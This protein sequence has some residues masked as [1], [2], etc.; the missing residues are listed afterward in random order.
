MP[1]TSTQPNSTCEPSPEALRSWAESRGL[2]WRPEDT[3]P[4]VTEHL[5]LGLG[6]GERRSGLQTVTDDGTVV[7]DRRAKRPERQTLGVVEGNLPGGLN[8][9]LGHH[10]FLTARSRPRAEGDVR[11]LAHAATALFAELPFGARPVFD[12]R[13]HHSP[14]ESPRDGVSVGPTQPNVDPLSTAVPA[15]ESSL[16]Y[17]DFTW[18]GFPAESDERIATIVAEA[19]TLTEGLPVERIEVEYECGRL[20]VWVIGRYLTAPS[21]LDQLSRFASAIASGMAAAVRA[22]PQFRLEETVGTLPGDQRARWIGAGTDLLEWDAPPVSIYAA[23]E[24]YKRDVKP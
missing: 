5:R 10:V 1:A 7:I 13:G 19:V 9:C 21:A 14:E 2:A 4:P 17:A 6:A 8:G 24:R 12:L 22:T 15:R 11:Y 3:F 20:A 18:R 23:Q 16:S